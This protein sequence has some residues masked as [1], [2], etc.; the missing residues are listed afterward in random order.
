M[1]DE[2]FLRRTFELARRGLGTTWPNPLVGAVIVKDGRVIAEG[3]H[4]RPGEAHAELAAIESATEP[5]EDATV[6]VNLEP[7]CHTDKRTPPCAQRLIREGVRRVVFANLDPNP[8]VNGRGVELLRAHGIAV[9]HGLLA[10]EGERLNEVFF[11]SQRRR[12]PFLHLKVAATLDGKMALPSGESQWITGP[13]ARAYVHELRARHQAIL[14]GGGTVRRDDPRLTVRIPGAA[15][16]RP[17]RIVLTRS[18]NLPPEARVFT[19]EHRHRTLVY[20]HAPLAFPFPAAQVVRVRNLRDVLADLFQRK[21][22]C[23]MLECGP[24]LASA[25][26][27]ERL[28]DRL[29]LFQS[30]TII[31]QGHAIFE[32]FTTEALADRPRLTELETRWIGGDQLI[33]GRTTCLRD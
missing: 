3:H 24:G 22:I 14:V 31:G 18:G 21:I 32:G 6:Y 2:T 16:A 29:T 33:T 5:L 25:F 9:D 12:R 26:L 23:V 27:R 1:T 4:V 11:H 10:A 8:A 7:C 13:E 19:D 15:E 30:P 28:L 20:T 17:W